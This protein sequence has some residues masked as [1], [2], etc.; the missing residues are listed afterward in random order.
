MF[1]ENNQL[2]GRKSFAFERSLLLSYYS[3]ELLACYLGYFR[4]I[5]IVL[6]PKL[7]LVEMR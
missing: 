1:I 6:S 4:V 5:S 7:T 3:L 2:A